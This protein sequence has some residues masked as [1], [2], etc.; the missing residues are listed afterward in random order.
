[1]IYLYF[2]LIKKPT[3]LCKPIYFRKRLADEGASALIDIKIRLQSSTQAGKEG[4]TPQDKKYLN[5]KFLVLEW[6]VFCPW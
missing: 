2:I 1:M 5:L 4:K 6:V 3:P